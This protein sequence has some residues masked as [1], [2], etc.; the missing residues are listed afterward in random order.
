MQ[1]QKRS[2]GRRV[3]AWL[4]EAHGETFRDGKWRFWFPA[5]IGFSILNAALTAVVFGSGGHL[6][7]FMFGVL[8][9]VGAL[10]AWL[11][12][13][14]LHYS[15]SNDPQLARGV[16]A[17]DSVTLIFVIA[18]FCFLLFIYGHVS[19]LKAAEAKYEAGATNYNDRAERVIGANVEI[20]KSNERIAEANAKA[21]KLR[22]DT[23]YQIRRANERGARV[24][25]GQIAPT[26]AAGLS[27]SLSTAPVEL[28]K[29]TKPAKSSTEFLTTW[30]FWV[31]LA[32]FGE[33][34]LA[35]ITLIFIRNRSAKTN[36]IRPPAPGPGPRQPDQETKQAE[37]FPSEIDANA[38]K[39]DRTGRRLDRTRNSDSGRLSPI[40]GDLAT[41][42]E[43]L[44]KLREHLKAIAFYYPGLWFKA[45]LIRGGVTIRLFKKE[46]SH[47][48][49]VATTDQS[50]KLLEAV[51]RPDF[52]KRLLDELL[53]QG[54]PLEEKAVE[55]NVKPR[56]GR[57]GIK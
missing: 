5:L 23:A 55:V 12:V 18:H 16:S 10:L 1:E 27:P 21:E 38:V 33:I 13:G 49:M 9:G 8:L 3:N 24:P 47:E 48:I 56:R 40:S 32:N 22:N 6:E 57:K 39:D 17:L 30:D 46:N 36:T 31:R 20:A 54:F 41:R 25:A 26:A 51:D 42:K 45:D 7:Q 14:A 29:P 2:F 35:A 34:A 15:D 28:E 37:D 53:R 4:D 43:A 19:M 52:R 11:G 50:D 44:R